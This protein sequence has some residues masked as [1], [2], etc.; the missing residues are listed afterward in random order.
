MKHYEKELNPSKKG[1]KSWNY[2][3][4]P[5][6]KPKPKTHQ[7]MIEEAHRIIEVICH[8]YE[9]PYKAIV[10]K[11]RYPRLVIVRHIAMHFIKEKTDLSLVDIGKIFDRDHTTIIYSLRNVESKRTHPYD[12]S[13]KNDLFNINL[14]L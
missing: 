5:S 11:E 8:Y 6:A 10:G 7:E 12:D 3:S 1:L 4:I 2:W 13:V 14:I 9:L